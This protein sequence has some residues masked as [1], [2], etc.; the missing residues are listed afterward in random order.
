MAQGYMPLNQNSPPGMAGRWAAALGRATPLYLQPVQV[1]LPSK[2]SVTFYDVSHRK[3]Q[4]KPAPALARMG[5]GFVFRFRITVDKTATS[6]AVTLYPSIELIDRLH[7]PLGE[8]D[9]F[10]LPV[11]FTRQE[12][13]LALAG[14]M[15]TKVVYLEQPQLALPT[16]DPLP[17][18]TLPPDRNLIKEADRRGRPMAIIRLG[19][20]QPDSDEEWRF[21]GRGGPIQ[22]PTR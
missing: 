4:T 8:A 2:G 13:E 16:S 14:K 1:I 17:S 22:V 21:I 15:V 20:R 10:P 19:G 5:V 12:I 7:P 11:R 3:R 18:V 6:P 9:K